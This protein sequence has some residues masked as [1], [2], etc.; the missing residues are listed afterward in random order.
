[1]LSAG[2]NALAQSGFQFPRHQLVVTVSDTRS[3]RI[4]AAGLCPSVLALTSLCQRGKCESIDR[5]ECGGLLGS[6]KAAKNRQDIP[7]VVAYCCDLSGGRPLISEAVF[8][9]IYR[10]ATKA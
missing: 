4:L 7:D 9:R 2:L 3:S 10:H 6:T 5:T 1:M 8:L